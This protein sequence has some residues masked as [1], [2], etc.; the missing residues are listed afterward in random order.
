LRGVGTIF[1]CGITVSAPT[2]AAVGERVK[3][4]AVCFAPARLCPDHVRKQAERLPARVSDGKGSWI[5]L[6]GF[7]PEDLGPY[8]PLLPPVGDALR[9]KF[10]GKTV[11]V[12]E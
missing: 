7:R 9:L 4:G 8:E 11:R 2:L 12:G 3:Q 10:K 1:L 6:A 5:V